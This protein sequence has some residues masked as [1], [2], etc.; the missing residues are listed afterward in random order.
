MPNK[1]LD[2]DN[3][4]KGWLDTQPNSKPITLNYKPEPITAST[5]SVNNNVIQQKADE[6]T[7]NVKIYGTPEKALKANLISESNKNNSNKGTLSTTQ[8]INPNDR[9]ML[10]AANYKGNNPEQVIKANKQTQAIGA[11]GA[12]VGAIGSIPVVSQALGAGFAAKG[13][14]DIPETVK[15]VMDPNVSLHDKTKAVVFNSADFLGMG[16][17]TKGAK[18]LGD[19]ANKTMSK[20]NNSSRSVNRRINSNQ[21]SPTSFSDS[22]PYILF[23][24]TKSN[25]MPPPPSE[26]LTM[27]DGTMKTVWNQQPITEYVANSYKPDYIYN[28]KYTNILKNI[29]TNIFKNKPIFNSEVNLDMNLAETFQKPL[30]DSQYDKWMKHM[31]PG[32]EVQHISLKE[33]KKAHKE[34]LEKFKTSSAG[35]KEYG[36]FIKDKLAHKIPNNTTIEFGQ[37]G[38]RFYK[39]AFSPDT[40]DYTTLNYNHSKDQSYLKRATNEK[41]QQDQGYNISNLDPKE[42]NIVEAYAHGYDKSLNGVARNPSVGTVSTFYQD[43]GEILNKGILK[44]KFKEATTVR[45]G[46]GNDY[47]I[48]L[49]DPVTHT[50]TGV[51]K[52][53]SELEKGDVFQDK[54]FISTSTNPQS[55]WGRPELSETIEI[56]G[57]NIQSLAV[58][59]AATRTQFRNENEAILPKNLI[60]QI[61]DVNPDITHTHSTKYKSKILNPYTITGAIGTGALQAK[62]KQKYAK[63]GWLDKFEDG[64]FIPLNQNPLDNLPTPNIPKSQQEAEAMIDS[65]TLKLTSPSTSKEDKKI[66]K[67]GIDAAGTVFYPASLVGSAIDFY[68][69]DNVG[70]I[71][72][73]IPFG[74]G[75]KFLKASKYAGKGKT[76]RKANS[77]LN[78]IMGAH[79]G[80]QVYDAKSDLV[81]PLIKNKKYANGGEIKDMPFGM[82]LKEQNPFLVP[83]YNQPM[84]GKTILPD[85]NRPILEGTNASEFKTS[86]N[87]GTPDEIQIPTI[88]GGQYIGKK[89]ALERFKATGE[90]FKNMTD[91]R[92]YSNFYNQVGNLGLMKNNKL[93][94]EIPD[95]TNA[96]NYIKGWYNSPMYNNILKN[97][98]ADWG[99]TN[100]KRTDKILKRLNK[101]F[102]KSLDNSFYDVNPTIVENNTYFGKS[103]PNNKGGREINLEKNFIKN[104]PKLVNSLFTHELA[105]DNLMTGM[106]EKYISKNTPKYNPTISDETKYN[107]LTDPEEVRSQIHSIRQLSKENKIYDPFTQPFKKEYLN[108]INKSYNQGTKESEDYNQLQR[109][110]QFY[111]DDQI[112]EMMNTIS[113]SNSDNT[114]VVARN[115]GWLDNQ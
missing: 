45:R 73:L 22:D 46:I 44:N 104:N 51:T 1:W 109:L 69:G 80:T 15:T 110:R 5:T 9:W 41:F 13:V 67:Y 4:N 8:N 68:Q 107:F 66:I 3:I 31:Y 58:P 52:W 81:D 23:D 49:L 40:Y 74:K 86:Y 26:L 90:K 38:E 14:H 6:F 77:S 59:E 57:G 75:Y 48:E 76:A 70:G 103:V 106:D 61:T 47:K 19:F 62:E 87:T 82:P 93:D 35:G 91:P 42:R 37:D 53:R 24:G 64:G 50:P 115:G 27:P 39:Q 65:G 10:G 100:P 28:N 112:I 32:D 78:K 2:I 7:K 43:M 18:R 92:S 108:Q 11:I 20:F 85:I 63:G 36:L 95:V 56:P 96:K 30:S 84:V 54:S 101:N 72:G 21:L 99:V 60:K 33:F 83:E 111:S 94:N 89:E 29:N 71:A 88:V 105:H 55:S 113:K 12:G 17:A 79:V 114:K 98:I 97:Q 34:A 102:N 25:Q 16:E